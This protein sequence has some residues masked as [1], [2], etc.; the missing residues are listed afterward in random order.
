MPMIFLGKVLG[1]SMEIECPECGGTGR[2]EYERHVVDYERGGYIDGYFDD[3]D[4]CGGTGEIKVDIEQDEEDEEE[5]FI[6]VNLNN[7]GSIH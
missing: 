1:G 5:V 7:T 3:C 4:E 6:V 2:C